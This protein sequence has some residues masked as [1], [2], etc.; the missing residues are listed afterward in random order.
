MKEL[1]ILENI[2]SD[3]VINWDQTGIQDVPVSNWTMAKE[4]SHCDEIVGKDDKRQITAACSGTMSGDSFPCNLSTKGKLRNH[5][6]V[7]QPWS[8][9][10]E[11]H[12]Q[13]YMALADQNPVLLS[14]GSSPWQ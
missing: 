5:F 1:I 7:P 4:G 10:P 6:L 3:L 14:R 12:F 8:S 11:V 13:A 2:P 9:F